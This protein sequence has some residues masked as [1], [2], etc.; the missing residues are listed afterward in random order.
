MFVVKMLVIGVILFV[1]WKLVPVFRGVAH[2]FKVVATALVQALGNAAC[3]RQLRLGQRSA[4]DRSRDAALTFIRH[5][6]QQIKGI[7]AEIEQL[8]AV[9]LRTEMERQIEAVRHSDR[10]PHVIEAEVEFIT[11]EYD[12][13]LSELMKGEG[14]WTTSTGSSWRCS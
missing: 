13:K 9:E 3:K 14:T 1:L 2:C 11:K 8:R 10:E 6:E 4:G 5:G 12:R 7:D